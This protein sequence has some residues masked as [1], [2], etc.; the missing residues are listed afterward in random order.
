M[1]AKCMMTRLK[2]AS[3]LMVLDQPEIPL[4]NNPAE[5]GA[6]QRV[7][8]RCQLWTAHSRWSQSLA[9]LYNL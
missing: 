3:L 4:Y 5:L 9:Y 7:R 1:S 2:R 8:K 6:R